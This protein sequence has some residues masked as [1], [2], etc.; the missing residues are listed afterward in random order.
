MKAA[1]IEDFKKPMKVDMKRKV[2]SDLE[3]YDILV[4]IKAAGMCHTD[5]QVLEGVYKEAGSYTGMIG[6]HE[7]AGVVVKLGPKAESEGVVKLGDRVGSI[8]VS[9]FG[10]DNLFLSSS[11]YVS[12]PFH[13]RR[14]ATAVSAMHA[15]IKVANYARSFLVC[16]DLQKT[17]ALLNIARW[18]LESF[19][20]FLPASLM[21][22]L[23]LSFV[24]ARLCME[25][26]KL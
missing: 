26:C 11:S 22:K 9:G 15:S 5:L 19:L 21:T 16:W 6:S 2:P 25:L 4:Q 24:Q 14:M 7:P 23:H 8:N 13:Y 10:D 18:T 17:V 3:E 20:R 12:L 1:V